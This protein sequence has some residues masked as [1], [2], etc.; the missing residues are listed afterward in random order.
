VK[1]QSTDDIQSQSHASN[2][3]HDLWIL[4]SWDLLESGIHTVK[5]PVHTLNRDKPLDGL[6]SDAQSQRKQ[7]GPV[8]EST[9]ELSAR[10]TKREILRRRF[11]LCNL[12]SH[13]C[14]NESNEIV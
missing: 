8:E 9:E 6:Q 14:H 10:P 12:H 2:D 7:K 11:V 5:G 1:K 3:K 4:D 13:E